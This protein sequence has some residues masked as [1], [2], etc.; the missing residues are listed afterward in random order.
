MM[1]KFLAIGNIGKD[2][3]VTTI[4]NGSTVSKFSLATSENY[5]DKSGEWQEKTEWHNIV[6]WKD[7]SRLNK[8][9]SI[10][11]E[12]KIT[13]RKWQDKDGNNRYTTEV[14]AGYVRKLNKSDRNQIQQP[15]PQ[16]SNAAKGTD[17]DL[18]F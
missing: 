16:P 7:L 14:V 9:D 15:Q 11:L 5:K 13:T 6:C 17:D 2:V 1:Q 12:G 18:P 10:Y 4:P 3:E 8:G